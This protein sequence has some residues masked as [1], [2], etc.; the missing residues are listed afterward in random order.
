VQL[1]AAPH[2][3]DVLDT[4]TIGALRKLG[5]AG[6]L[7]ADDA[8]LLV[9]SAALQHALT[10]VLRIA[11]DG[12]LDPESATPGLKN[13]VVRAAGHDDFSQLEASL[14][15]AQAGVREIFERVLH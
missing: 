3:G 4:N 5:A 2:G 6:A 14:A 13:L 8:R 1:C 15:K 12:T 11:L 9:D 10:Q 7:S